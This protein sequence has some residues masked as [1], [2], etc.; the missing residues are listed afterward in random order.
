MV[1]PTV[2]QTAYKERH[3][4]WP[5]PGFEPHMAG[6]NNKTGLAEGAAGIGFGLAVS[7]GTKDKQVKLGGPVA[8]F[9]GISLR[10]ITQLVEAGDKYPEKSNVGYKTLGPIVVKANGVIAK[11]DAVF[12]D[13]LT[14]EFGN[15]RGTIAVGT[16]AYTGTGNGILTKATPAFSA[17]AMAGSYR[18]IATANIT[19]DGS[20]TVI[21]PDG[22]VDGVATVGEAY[23]GQVKFTI[24]DGA[25]DF[26]AGDTFVLPVTATREGPI[27]GARWETSAA[28]QALA[29]VQLGIQK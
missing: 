5:G 23:D 24:A 16:V 12:Y 25:T 7:Q 22:T 6:Y 2:V 18:A 27:P 11:N 21:R 8:N 20:F 19:N 26:V 13:A 15:S 4:A 1:Q 28:D 10:D 14:G 9:L 3:E 29:I 17:A